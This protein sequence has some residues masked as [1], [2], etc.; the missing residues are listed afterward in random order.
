MMVMVILMVMMIMMVMKQQIAMRIAKRAKWC[1]PANNQRPDSIPT[2]FTRPAQSRWDLCMHTYDN[3]SRLILFLMM[4]DL[5][6][7]DCD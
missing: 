1:R 6:S 3:G 4:I 2:T 5:S 7:S